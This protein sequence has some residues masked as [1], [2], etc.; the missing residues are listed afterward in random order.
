M[1][2]WLKAIFQPGGNVFFKKKKGIKTTE[3]VNLAE[4]K[5]IPERINWK[6]GILPTGDCF[7]HFDNGVQHFEC[8]MTEDTMIEMGDAM[9]QTA[10]LRKTGYAP[11]ESGVGPSLIP[12]KPGAK[13]Q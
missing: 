8:T 5:E 10:E 13:L 4:P 7:L 9:K 2:E 12:M 6:V 11:K 1:F 3:S